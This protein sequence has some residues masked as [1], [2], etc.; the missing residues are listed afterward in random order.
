M[1]LKR[2]TARST[3]PPPNEAAVGAAIKASGIPRDELFVTT[4]LWAEDASEAGARRAVARSLELLGLDRLDLYL[5]HQPV[6]DVYGAWRTM[7]P[8]RAIPARRVS[9]WT[10]QSTAKG[11][12]SK[13]WTWV[14]SNLRAAST[15]FQRVSKS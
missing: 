15:A 6:G 3:R 4:K 5:I 11:C 1:R 9:V 12:W 7:E 13:T 14:N 10:S 2:G 8:T